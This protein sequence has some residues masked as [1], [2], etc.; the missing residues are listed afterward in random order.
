MGRVRG[1]GLRLG[2]GARDGGS[3]TADLRFQKRSHMFNGE[4]KIGS[5]EWKSGRTGGAPSAMAGSWSSPGQLSDAKPARR[6]KPQSYLES[7]T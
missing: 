2:A 1:N 4:D 3:K 6:A 7:N 5:E